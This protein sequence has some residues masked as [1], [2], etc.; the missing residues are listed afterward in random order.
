MELQ[1][2]GIK[3][4]EFLPAKIAIFIRFLSIIITRP[5]LRIV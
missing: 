4:I 2:K 5:I 1:K 3:R